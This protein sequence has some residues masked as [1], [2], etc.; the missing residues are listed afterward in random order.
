[1]MMRILVIGS[2]GCLGRTLLDEGRAAGTEMLEAWGPDGQFCNVKS[3][4]SVQQAFDAALR[5]GP[6]DAVINTA[7][8]HD[9]AECNEHPVD[10]WAVNCQGVFNVARCC[11]LQ[12]SPTLMLQVSTDYVFGASDSDVYA[13]F[14]ATCPTSAAGMYGA[15]KAAGELAVEAAAPFTHIVRMASLFGH[16]P[17]VMKHGRP[18]IVEFFRQKLVA[19]EK[20]DA[21]SNTLTS[22]SYAPWSARMI[23]NRV[24]SWVHHTRFV[25]D[26]G[27]YLHQ[28]SH[29][30]CSG[31][32]SHYDIA[33]QVARELGVDGRGV[34]PCY[35]PHAIRAALRPG[36]GAS[37]WHDAI[38]AYLS[39]LQQT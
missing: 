17:S 38:H 34:V 32:V 21:W 28:R 8:L 9:L 22:I 29:V 4:L 3:P 6:L 7:A 31:Y 12:T 19:G 24:S 39:R 20:I 36:D 23:L 5:E 35:K 37:L 2:T 11:A 1:M 16:Y 15:S 33:L 25:A 18:N 26:Q 13:P 27:S 10:A 14:D 30:V